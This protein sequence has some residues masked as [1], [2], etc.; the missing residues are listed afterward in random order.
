MEVRVRERL[1]GALVLVAIVVLLVPA[2]LKGRGNTPAE[3]PAE[4]TRR[5]EVPTSDA[6]PPPAESVLV[7]EPV[8]DADPAAD[9]EPA[10]TT[11][12]K[13]QRPEPPARRPDTNP[14]QPAGSTASAPPPTPKAQAAAQAPSKAPPVAP[15]SKS[16]AT[17]WAVQLGA[18][19]NRSKAEQ[20]VAQLKERRY[21][22]FVLEYRASG[23]VLYRVRVGP[24]Q[25]RAR[26]EEIAARLAKD[27]FQTVVA[28]HP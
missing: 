19:S 2:I 11:S 23:Q 7:P 17:A 6:P 13:A 20:L 10:T 26:A 16:T 15:A 22:A 1:I 4:S 14:D 24:E 21:A 18:F 9:A 8:A 25:E 3:P 27:G 12:T 28:R 5:V